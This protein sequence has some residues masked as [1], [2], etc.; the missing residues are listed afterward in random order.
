MAVGQPNPRGKKLDKPG[1][2]ASRFGS[3]LIYILILLVGFLLLRS[4][5]QDAGFQRVPSSGSSS[6]SRAAPPRRSW[7]AASPPGPPTT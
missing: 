5:F 3:P 7:S 1:G 4:L 6:G 2:G